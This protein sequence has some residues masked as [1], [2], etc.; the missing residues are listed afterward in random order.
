MLYDPNWKSP[1]TKD[2]VIKALLDAAALIRKHGLAKHVERDMNGA[3]CIHGAIGIAVHGDIHTSTKEGVADTAWREVI[4]YLDPNH[5]FPYPRGFA[6]E[7]VHCRSRQLV[8]WNNAP[9][10]TANEVIQALEHTV[11]HLLDKEYCNV[12]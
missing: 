8:E 3:M 2:K 5:T 7:S 11:M 10:R 9:Q 6:S 1:E 4:N 12:I